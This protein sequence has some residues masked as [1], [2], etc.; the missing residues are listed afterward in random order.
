MIVLFYISFKQNIIP[1]INNNIVPN[2][3]EYLFKNLFIYFPMVNPRKVNE[4]LTIENTVEDN[5]K[6]SVIAL[7]PNPTEKLSNDTPKAKSKIPNLL[8]DI[9][10]LEGLR[11]SINICNDIKIRIIPNINSVFID[12]YF[13]I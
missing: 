12:K 13:V 9:S 2:K 5:N 8:S 1:I 11:Y 6:F 10:L 7:N 4:K 3:Y